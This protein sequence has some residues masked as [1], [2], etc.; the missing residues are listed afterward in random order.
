MIISV[1]VIEVTDGDKQ[2]IATLSKAICNGQVT[3]T[4]THIIPLTTEE[5]E[6]KNA[7]T[8]EKTE[9][10]SLYFQTTDVAVTGLY[11]CQKCLACNQASRII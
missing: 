11:K 8:T 3:W 10:Q 4:Q 9:I 5:D 1:A 6:K 7:G 2:N